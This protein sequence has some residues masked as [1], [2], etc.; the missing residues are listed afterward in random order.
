MVRI[1]LALSKEGDDLTLS[2]M[3]L[4]S[5]FVSKGSENCIIEIPPSDDAMDD[6]TKNIIT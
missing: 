4:K 6:K 3:L 5:S 2:R 1:S